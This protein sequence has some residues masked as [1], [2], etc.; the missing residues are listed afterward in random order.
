MLHD[1]AEMVLN[2]AAP[3][4]LLGFESH[5]KTLDDALLTDKLLPAIEAFDNYIA[6]MCLGVPQYLTE[7]R[8]ELDTVEGAFGTSDVVMY[9]DNRD[10]LIILD[11]KFGY[12]SVPASANDQ[13]AYYCNGVLS[14]PDVQDWVSTASSVELVIIQAGYYDVWQTTLEWVKS[15]KLAFTKAIEAG[16]AGMGNFCTGDHCKFC[17]VLANN[18]CP[19]H[20]RIAQ[21]ALDSG[22]VATVN[23][24]L[25]FWMSKVADLEA[26]TKAIKAATHAALD[27]GYD[28][29]GYKLVAKRAMHK[30]KDTDA[31]E[32]TLRKIARRNTNHMRV[33][34]IFDSKMKSP[35]QVVALF[36]K[37]NLDKSEVTDQIE[38]ISS[39]TTVALAND[40]RPEILGLKGLANLGKL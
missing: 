2:G 5:G 31:T 22:L 35:A 8:V 16:D 24:D 36:K 37:H 40:K 21:G 15:R 4:T 38:S 33:S 18:Q 28:I 14:H 32:V 19:E 34:D 23:D 20:K 30:W 29:A 9:D 17:P 7:L 27:S 11:W 13:L 1:A 10:C 6:N 12:V 26:F 25:A 3:Q 39:G